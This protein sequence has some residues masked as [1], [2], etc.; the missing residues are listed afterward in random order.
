[1]I[2]VVYIAGLGR[3][4][5]TL[6][7]R[8]LGQVDGVASI[9]E[10]HH[11]WRTGALLGADDELCGC[12][13]SF[14]ACPF[15]T[16]L[17]DAVVE[18]TPSQLEKLRG[19]RDRVARIR[20]VR[21]LERGGSAQFEAW[22]ATYATVWS[23]I[24]T[25]VARRSDCRVVVDASKDL[26]P[27]FFLLRLPEIDVRVLHLTRDPR[28]VA[29]SW[30][31]RKRRPEFVDREVYMH[32][33]GPLSVAWRWWYSNLLAERAGRAAPAYL[34]LRYEDLVERPRASLRAVTDWTGVEEADLTFLDGARAALDRE[35]HILSGNPMRF[36][37]DAVEIRADDA[38][39]TRMPAARR[40]C[41]AA[42]TWPLRR[43]YESR[44]TA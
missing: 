39:R 41:V 31:R 21:S 35:T 29:H 24:Y 42:L 7:A 15:W 11:L 1:M 17:L 16:P 38:W 23:A 9:G 2:R 20:H 28:A 18:R 14:A 10:A 22:V 27:L 8:L 40:A 19:L 33:H 43:R 4:G 6:L 34:H 37:S 36:E 30:G 26:G 44:R 12:G 32:R 5:S 25:E 3:S 13:R